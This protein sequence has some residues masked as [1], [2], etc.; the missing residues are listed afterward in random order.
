MPAHHAEEI[1]QDWCNNTSISLP[2]AVSLPIKFFLSY[3]RANAHDRTARE[4]IESIFKSLSDEYPGQVT[5]YIDTS[6][7]YGGE[8]VTQTIHQQIDQSNV[9]LPVISRD[10]FKSHNCKKEL[11][12][13]KRRGLLCIPIYYRE[14]ANWKRHF[15]SQDELVAWPTSGMHVADPRWGDDPGFRADAYWAAVSD[16]MGQWLQR[17]GK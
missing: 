4:E 3:S 8:K 2:Q 17:C 14:T 1:P 10:Y 11:A 12:H 13:A 15:D 16:A 5:W 6:H 9:F 7:M